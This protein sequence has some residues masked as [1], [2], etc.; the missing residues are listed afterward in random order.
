MLLRAFVQYKS[1]AKTK[2]LLQFNTR[3]PLTKNLRVIIFKNR[4]ILLFEVKI[5]HIFILW[6]HWAQL[7]GYHLGTPM[8]LWLDGCW[9]WVIWRLDWGGHPT[10]LTHMPSRWH[11]P[12]VGTSAGAGDHSKTCNLS[13]WLQCLMACHV[14][15]KRQCPMRKHS[16]IPQGERQRFFLDLKN[17]T[18]LFKP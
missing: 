9:G 8:R 5:L 16:K 18:A 6:G 4:D 14:G 10:W 13:M 11:W 3:Y 17:H 7:R 2:H 1:P 15:S 12:S